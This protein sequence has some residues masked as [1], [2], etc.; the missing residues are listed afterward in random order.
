MAAALS[1]FG[2]KSQK[3][4]GADLN[5]VFIYRVYFT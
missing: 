5:T 2:K 4:L 3:F 1:Q